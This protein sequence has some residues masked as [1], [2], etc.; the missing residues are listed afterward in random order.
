MEW[1]PL[2]VATCAAAT[3]CGGIV[4]A[5][6][7]HA[8]GRG[9]I[10]T[11]MITRV[12]S[13][14]T[15]ATAALAKIELLSTQLRDHEVKDAASF[16]ELRATLAANSAAQIQAEHRT[17]KAIEDFGDAINNMTRRI[18]DLLKVRAG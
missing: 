10:D 2:V 17:A 3:V 9:R 1:T 13:V 12:A 4:G 5:I 18:D 15:I 14:E 16:A 8:Y 11:T 6:I 7:K